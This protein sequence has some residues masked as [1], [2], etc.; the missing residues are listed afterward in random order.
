VGNG[1]ELTAA[2]TH[3]PSLRELTGQLDD[4]KELIQ[5]EL[6]GIREVMQERDRRY[7]AQFRN[8]E[9][10]VKAALA[11]AEKQTMAAFQASEKAI[12]KAEEAQKS[13]NQT[14]NDL[15]R[16]MDEQYKTMI[17][18]QEAE[19][20]FETWN[21]RLNDMKDQLGQTRE[22]VLRELSGLRESGSREVSTV[23]NL[24]MSEIQGLRESRS[25]SGGRSAGQT[26][27]QSAQQVSNSFI[28]ACIIAAVGL[29]ALIVSILKFSH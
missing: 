15:S 16:K 10:N 8:G 6:R 17:P 2:R 22:E 25:E 28:V 20:Q 23:R 26:V 24:V 12:V 18:R 29:G 9:E 7:D 27:A 5:S 21:S 19:K 13:Y 3:E 4:L 14:H 11:A 1:T